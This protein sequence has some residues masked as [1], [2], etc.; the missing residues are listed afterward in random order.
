MKNMLTISL[1]VLFLLLLAGCYNEDST[2]DILNNRAQQTAEETTEIYDVDTQEDVLKLCGSMLKLHDWSVL[3][4]DKVTTRISD[5]SAGRL[6]AQDV[7]ETI[8]TLQRSCNELS[9]QIYEMPVPSKLSK[10]KQDKLKEGANNIAAG[11]AKKSESLSI[12]LTYLNNPESQYLKDAKTK[13]EESIKLVN[14]GMVSMLQV[15]YEIT[16]E[17]D[18]NKYLER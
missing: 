18:I 9:T 17:S 1:C 10:E 6:K 4:F 7:Y 12:I 16:G 3:Q 8:S 14:D 11:Y 15:F 2:T 5:L 13:Q